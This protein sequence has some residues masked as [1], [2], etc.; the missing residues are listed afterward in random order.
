MGGGRPCGVDRAVLGNPGK[1]TFCF[2]EDEEASPWESLAVER[3]FEPGASTVTLFGGDGVQ[4][5]VDQISRTPESL[6]RSFAACLRTVAHPKLFAVADAMLV[7]A[8]EHAHCV[9]RSRLV[10]TAFTEGNRW[11]SDHAWKGTRPGRAGNRG[12]HAATIRGH[13]I[14]QV[15]AGW[16]AY[17]ACRGDAPVSFRPLSAVGWPA[18]LKAA[19]P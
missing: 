12:R 8:P 16:V 18:A 9:C 5:A 11:G 7:V 10:Q 1:Y 15:Q 2:A 13:H 19:N 4:A 3:G 14:D 6:A 17:R